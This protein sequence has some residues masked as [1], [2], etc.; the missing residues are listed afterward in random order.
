MK[1]LLLHLPADPD[2]KISDRTESL[3]L[4]YITATLRRDGHEVEIFD[5]HLRCLDMKETIREVLAC[6]F[7]CLGITA[8]HQEKEKLI[9]VAKAV[10]KQK[11]DAIICAGGYAVTLATKALLEA[12]PEL[13]FAIRG[14]GE[15]VA[16]D[17][18]D[19][20]SRNQEWHDSP[21]IAFRKGEQVIIN[22]LPSL[23]SDLDTLPFATH[24][25]LAQA[26]G[27]WR[28][29]VSIASSRGCYHRCSF[30]SVNTF[31][32]LSG[33][34]A[35]RFRSAQNVAD[36][37]ESVIESTGYRSFSFADDDFIGPGKAREHAIAIADQIKARNMKIDFSI[38]CRADEVDEDLLRMLKDIG[39]TGIFLGIES[40]VQ[41]QLDT[42]NKKIS[43]EQNKRAI[44]M[45]RKLDIQMQPGFIPFDP[46]TTVDELQQNMDFI[47]EV[48]L[49]QGKSGPTPLRIMLFPGVQLAE[50]VKK[51]GLLREKRM[52]LDYVFKDKQVGMMWAGFQRSATLFN[53]VRKVKEKLG[54]GKG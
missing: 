3:G 1:V 34:H 45:V 28:S 48:D 41:R 10:R 51:D 32:E 15:T 18:F 4:A 37:M 22:P 12:C 26:P 30:C 7:D 42:Y 11:K 29:S 49:W 36:E 47:K 39:L 52:D 2:L 43:V 6:S 13:D 16:S 21:G 33:G 38:E 27:G 50:Q 5:A 20:I 44:E 23:I 19:K 24:D 31:Y 25:A 40:G 46:Y 14:E 8:M 9:A 53:T 35:P 54:L 17:V